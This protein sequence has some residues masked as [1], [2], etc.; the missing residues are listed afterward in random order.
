MLSIRVSSSSAVYEPDSAEWVDFR[1]RRSSKKEV[2][3]LGV[4]EA[5]AVRYD[6]SIGERLGR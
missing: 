2:C 6:L 3:G 1:K 5:T 4:T